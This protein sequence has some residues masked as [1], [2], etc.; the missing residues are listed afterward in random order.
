MFYKGSKCERKF[1]AETARYGKRQFFHKINALHTYPMSQL[2]SL[3]LKDP[4]I[5]ALEQLGDSIEEMWGCAS[6]RNI[7]GTVVLLMG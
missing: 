1:T 7:Y 6:R 5:V 3:W 4:F 2:N